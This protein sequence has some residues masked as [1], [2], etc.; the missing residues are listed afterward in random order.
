[1]ECLSHYAGGRCVFFKWICLWGGGAKKPLKVEVVEPLEN[2]ELRLR[3]ST[4]ETK[5]FDAK[6]ILETPL[7]SPLKDEKL[8]DRVYLDME[9]QLGKI[10]KLIFL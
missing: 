10:M 7:Y 2:F 1:M 3:F 5:I 4:G 8:F 6:P 9:F